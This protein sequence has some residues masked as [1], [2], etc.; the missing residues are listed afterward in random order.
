MYVLKAGGAPVASATGDEWARGVAL[1]AGPEL[2][3]AEK[4]REA[5]AYKNLVYYQYWRPQN[6]TYIFG[7]RKREQGHLQAEFPQFPPLVAQKEAEIAK[8]RVPV[9]QEYVL[10]PEKK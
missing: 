7:F 2:A 6:D 1:P 3:Q 8:L 10:E 5:I 9:P 4:L